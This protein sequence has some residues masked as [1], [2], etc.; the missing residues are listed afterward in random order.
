MITAYDR[1]GKAHQVEESKA[2]L[3]EYTRLYVPTGEKERIQ[4]YFLDELAALC[5]INRLNE[6]E[7]FHKYY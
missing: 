2:I 1:E 5:C 6:T 4:Q 7:P 3:F